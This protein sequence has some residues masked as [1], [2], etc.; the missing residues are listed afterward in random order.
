VHYFL[1]LRYFT[2]GIGLAAG[3]LFAREGA[4]VVLVDLKANALKEAASTIDSPSVRTFAA[5]VSNADEVLAYMSYAAKEFGGIDILFD[6]AG[7]EGVAGPIMTA[8][9]ED[10]QRVIDVN[11][12]GVWLGIKYAAQEMAKRGGGSIIVTS[13]IAG[14]RGF[15]GLSPYVAS[16][17]AVIGVMQSAAIELGSLGI[18]VNTINPGPVDNRMMRSV[19]KQFSPN[20][21]AAAQAGFVQKIPLGRYAKN[22]EVA[23]L[24]LFLA[25]DESKYITGG[26]HV[27]D[28][29]FT[30]G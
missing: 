10:F 13:S 18:R 22:E 21:P 30:A 11:L 12:K 28:G 1:E 7:I 5:D 3:E 20:D 19:E 17:H 25:S 29:G 16:K 14:I 6:N 2:G 9:V 23:Q 15:A 24:A 4:N 8:R 27:I 26:I